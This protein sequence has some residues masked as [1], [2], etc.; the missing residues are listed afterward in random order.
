MSSTNRRDP[1][2]A[3]RPIPKAMHLDEPTTID[4]RAPRFSDGPRHG[5]F[6]SFVTPVRSASSASRS[7]AQGPAATPPNVIPFT[8]PRAIA[9]V[10]AANPNAVVT[11]APSTS[12]HVQRRETKR[13]AT[14]PAPIT[15]TRAA[16]PSP[17]ANDSWS[18]PTGVSQ[19]AVRSAKGSPA[20]AI[21]SQS[22]V[23]T[24]WTP[25]HGVKPVAQP[26]S[27]QGPAIAVTAW[28]AAN[29]PSTSISS[30]ATAQKPAQ[31]APLAI[32]P[33]AQVAHVAHVAA[34]PAMP[35]AQ[36]RPHAVAP[37]MPA[38]AMPAMPPAAP[39]RQAV[40]MPAA[41][42]ADPHQ[43]PQTKWG[44]Y[45]QLGLGPPKLQLP[46]LLRKINSQ[47]TAK[48]IVNAYRLLGF[49]ILTIIVIVLVGYIA[50]T[51]FYYFSSSWIVP[52]AV[53]ATDEKVVGLSAQLAEQQNS[54]DRLADELQQ[55]ERSIA[56]QQLFQT[57]FA[58]AIRSDLEGRK[59]ALGR[60]RDLATNASRTRAAIKNQNSAYANASRKRMQQEY[61]AG[62]IDRSAMLSG[63]FQLAQ[64][65]SSNLSL[66]ERQA[67]FETRAAELEAQ[68]RSLDAVLA[69]AQGNAGT[70]LSY[71]VLRIKREYDA[72]RLDLAKAIESRDTLKSALERQNKIVSALQQSAYLRA[73]REKAQVAF[74]PYSNLSKAEK[75]SSLYACKLGMLFCYNAGE[76]LEV[77]PGEVQFKHPQRDRMLRGQMV[78][79]KLDEDDA[80]AAADDV[81]FVGGRP[82]LF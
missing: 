73:L 13:H 48:L 47:Q 45:H 54:R 51:A 4:A 42:V 38:P 39:A 40:Q 65:S 36:A 35:P 77:M 74:V 21:S 31:S 57:E 14:P 6:P 62:L 58:K 37:A 68:T 44:E 8:K 23:S 71:E 24:G 82:I 60:I 17:A 78:V 28:P 26:A 43:A 3:L 52:M 63:N 76:V 59:L 29:A 27:A 67:E 49:A 32:A 5:E 69:S 81:L 50:S 33:V 25:P 12:A 7:G 61:A 72:S 75:G 2:R 10:A 34:M 41:P 53:S 1:A 20:P 19:R 30:L 9:A 70:A 56:S 11:M 22:Q 64:I 46:K 66:A 16:S 80:D 79:L 55:A 15:T 18:N